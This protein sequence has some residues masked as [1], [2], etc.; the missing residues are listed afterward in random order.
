MVRSAQCCGNT[1]WSALSK[2]TTAAA[3]RQIR[4]YDPAA[5]TGQFFREEIEVP[6]LSRKAGNANYRRAVIERSPI[7]VCNAMPATEREAKY[8]RMAIRIARQRRRS[9]VRLWG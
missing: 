3:T 4:A 1:Y 2:P 9:V 7:C 6:T 5:P 8:G